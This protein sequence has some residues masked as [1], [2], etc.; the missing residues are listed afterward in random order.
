MVVVLVG[1]ELFGV[2]RVDDR[3][4][5]RKSLSGDDDKRSPCAVLILTPMSFP[6]GAYLDGGGRALAGRWGEDMGGGLEDN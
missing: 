6:G 3:S 1:K 2:P 4:D 5:T